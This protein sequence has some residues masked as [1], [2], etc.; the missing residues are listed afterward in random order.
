MKGREHL[1]DMNQQLQVN[2]LDHG[3][4]VKVLEQKIQKIKLNRRQFIHIRLSVHDSVLKMLAYIR[5]AG[6]N[7]FMER[8]LET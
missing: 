6:P 3:P 2:M 7:N 5:I 8:F 1:E 4:S